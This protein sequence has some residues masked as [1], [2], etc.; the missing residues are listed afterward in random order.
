MGW[1]D[2]QIRQRKENDQELFQD[3][4][5]RLAGVVLGTKAASDLKDGQ[6]VTK[7]AIEEILKY[8]H[9]KAKEIP[10]AIKNPDEQLEYQL[11]P[12]QP[13]AYS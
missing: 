5:V 1:F 4:F 11:R 12:K 8:Y 3:S 2:E 13:A 9:F 7:A 10:A 6:L